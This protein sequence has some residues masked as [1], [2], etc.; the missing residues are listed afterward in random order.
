MIEVSKKKRRTHFIKD[1]LAIKR[2]SINN[3]SA[4]VKTVANLK[5]FHFYNTESAC[6]TNMH[7]QNQKNDNTKYIVYLHI[8]IR[9]DSKLLY[10]TLARAISNLKSFVNELFCFSAADLN[11]NT[12]AFV[13]F[14]VGFVLLFLQ[15][16]HF[17]FD[18]LHQ[19]LQLVYCHFGFDQK[20]IW[21]QKVVGSDC[22]LGFLVL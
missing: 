2:E 22:L 18:R 4:F 11:F 12:W 6:T 13:H 15:G 9:K 20:T 5:R 21:T 10:A 8:Q 17:R 16:S 7:R 14:D 3:E 19:I 1:S